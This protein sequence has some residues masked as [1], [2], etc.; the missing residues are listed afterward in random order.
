MG[1]ARC[2]L[3]LA[4]T[5][6]LQGTRLREAAR[7]YRAARAKFRSAGCRFGEVTCLN[8]EAELARIQGDIEAAE[9]GYA[10]AA[11][12]TERLGRGDVAIVRM[13]LAICMMERGL[14]IESQ[15][16]LKHVRGKLKRQHRSGLVG[17]ADA[18][19]LC[20]YA[21]RERWDSWEDTVHS[22]RTRLENSGLVDRDVAR[23][24]EIAGDL[25]RDA[26][27]PAEAELAWELALHQWDALGEEE[28][29]R[30]I[31]GRSAYLT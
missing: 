31:E 14:Y 7:H 5:L 11:E 1:L 19:S 21:R 15:R 9:A 17:V 30:S 3:N 16:A 22:A 12:L 6:T 28:R 29:V 20:G 25:A 24:C 13:N 26:G 27:R 23:F 18:L 2:L 4:E 8:G 10:R